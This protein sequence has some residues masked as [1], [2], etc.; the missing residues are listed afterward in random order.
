MSFRTNLR[1]TAALTCLAFTSSLPAQT[2]VGGSDLQRVINIY[3][4]SVRSYGVHKDA[5]Q[6][7]WAFGESVD[8]SVRAGLAVKLAHFSGVMPVVSAI[9]EKS[10][11]IKVSASKKIRIDIDDIDAGVFKIA[12]KRFVWSDDENFEAN[13]KRIAAIV[14]QSGLSASLLSLLITEAYAGSLNEAPTEAERE[15]LAKTK[16][17]L[18]EQKKKNSKATPKSPE[19]I[20]SEAKKTCSDQERKGKGVCS[21]WFWIGIA[22]AVVAAA[23]LIYFLVK[24]NKKD[25]EKK[26]KKPTDS[27]SGGSSGGEGEFE[28][29]HP[30]NDAPDFPNA[31]ENLQ[32]VTEGVVPEG[33]TAPTHVSEEWTTVEGGE[34]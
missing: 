5:N 7:L 25:K 9:G 14:E 6:F 31:E 1:V 13:A 11:E 12:G 21:A 8:S 19:E 33:N 17:Y 24:K 10:F 16:K 3:E 29:T 27:G 2:N 28:Q 20:K 22:V 23:L 26:K 18:E 4:Q 15:A 34:Q 32:T 30:W